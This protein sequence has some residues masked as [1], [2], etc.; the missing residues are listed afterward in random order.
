MSPKSFRPRSVQ[1]APPSALLLTTLPTHSGPRWAA[2]SDSGP[3]TPDRAPMGRGSGRRSP[4]TAP[5]TRRRRRRDA[6]ARAPR[7]ALRQPI[8]RPTSPRSGGRGYQPGRSAPGMRRDLRPADLD[9]RACRP[10]PATRSYPGHRSSGAHG[11][12]CRHG[13]APVRGKG[14]RDRSGAA[15]A[16]G[17]HSRRS[18]SGCPGAGPPPNWR[19]CRGCG[20]ASAGWELAGRPDRRR[21]GRGRLGSRRRR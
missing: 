4:R 3:R 11:A 6:P 21:A 9:R 16:G 5:E 10:G 7:S 12:W 1:V 13:R 14:G 2:R 20:A 8:G 18:P 17:R 19:R 15:R